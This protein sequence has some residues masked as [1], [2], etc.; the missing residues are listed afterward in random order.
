MLHYLEEFGM[1]LF[2]SLS[3][4][5]LQTIFTLSKDNLDCIRK[6]KE[7]LQLIPNNSWSLLN[8]RKAAFDDS[9]DETHPMGE[10]AVAED[11]RS[12]DEE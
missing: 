8:I 4:E 6:M 12:V 9:S 11:P 1:D 10:S 7:Y 3:P 5:Q 2:I